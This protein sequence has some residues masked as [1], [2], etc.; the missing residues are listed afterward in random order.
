MSRLNLAARSAQIGFSPVRNARAVW[1]TIVD[2]F[3]YRELLGEMVGPGFER[4]PCI[5]WFWMVYGFTFIP[6]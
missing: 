3:K 4:C 2:V 1:A 6:S 5:A